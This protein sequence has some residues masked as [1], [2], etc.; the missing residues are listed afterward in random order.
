MRV[1]SP[2]GMTK[3]SVAIAP[4]LERYAAKRYSAGDGSLQPEVKEGVYCSADDL[5]RFGMFHL[6]THLRS[7]KAT[8]SDASIDLMQNSTV[9][10]PQGRFTLESLVACPELRS[11][12]QRLVD[13]H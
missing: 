11:L 7:Q 4:G 3:C 12:R 8:L 2:L 9:P 10:T 13:K 5:A 6:K 1:L